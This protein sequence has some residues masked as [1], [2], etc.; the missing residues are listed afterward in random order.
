M[1]WLGTGYGAG[2]HAMVAG[3]LLVFVRLL[4]MEGMVRG[5]IRGALPS[6]RGGQEDGDEDEELGAGT[7]WVGWDRVGG[8]GL[9]CMYSIKYM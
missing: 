2:W 9:M 5:G 4:F 8:L 6:Y 3:F 7:G 1:G